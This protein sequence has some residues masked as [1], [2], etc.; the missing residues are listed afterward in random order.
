VIGGQRS[1]KSGIGTPRV[2]LNAIKRTER[3]ERGP[4][5]DQPANIPPGLILQGLYTRCSRGAAPPAHRCRPLAAVG[6]VLFQQHKNSNRSRRPRRR[7]P[8]VERW[9]KAS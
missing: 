3:T 9:P 5:P 4:R 2:L 6:P 8:N 7:Y 1:P